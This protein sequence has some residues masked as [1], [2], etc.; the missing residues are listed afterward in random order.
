MID[1]PFFVLYHEVF[2]EFPDEEDNR[3]VE[4]V[5]LEKE[6]LDEDEHVFRC[7]DIVLALFHMELLLK[8]LIKVSAKCIS[9]IYAFTPSS[10]I[11]FIIHVII[12]GAIAYPVDEI[13]E[14]LRRTV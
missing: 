2:D 3:S 5:L 14:I 1:A 13:F 9:H 10:Q 4:V 12:V 6:P 11:Y 8:D 7:L